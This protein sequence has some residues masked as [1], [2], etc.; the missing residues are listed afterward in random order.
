MGFGAF[1]A[2]ASVGG[3]AVDYWALRQAGATPHGSTRRVL[4]LNT[5]EWA[6]LTFAPCVVD[7]PFFARR[8]APYD[9]NRPRPISAARLAAATVDAR[10][11]S[12]GA[13][14]AVV[15][16]PA[17][18]ASRRCALALPRARRAVGLTGVD[19]PSARSDWRSEPVAA[20]TAVGS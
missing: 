18:V 1:F 7:T 6:A 14:D 5:L 2:G 4:A 19:A 8:G 17:G 11:E 13:D 20:R 9:R 15:A 12:P 10:G 16:Q 3:L